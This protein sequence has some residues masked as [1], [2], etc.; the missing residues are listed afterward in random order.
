MSEWWEDLRAGL[1]LIRTRAYFFAGAQGPLS[2]EVRRAVTA[3]LDRWDETGWHIHETAWRHLDDAERGLAALVG[4]SPSRVA[5]AGSTTHGM[6]LAAA[7]VLARW[8]RHGAPPA[9]V[10]MHHQGHSAGTY[11]WLNEVRLGAKLELRWADPAPGQRTAD[12]LADRVDGATIA[13]ILSHVNNWDGERIDVPGLAARVRPHRPALLV[14]AAQSAG[15]LDLRSLVE[16]ADF[17]AMPAYKWLLGPAGVAFLVVGAEWIADPGPPMPGWAGMRTPLPLD[18]RALDPAP[19]AASYRQGIPNFFGIAGAAAGIGLL[20][21][22]GAAEVE[23]RIRALTG[24]LVEGLERR[25]LP[26]TTPH[27]WD[28]RAGVLTVLVGTD[29]TRVATA[30]EGEGVVC[31]VERDAL[32]VDVHAYNNEDDLARLLAALDAHASRGA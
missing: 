25:R 1:P 3:E 11:A 12:A 19:T 18:V 26:L 17:V 10:V 9:N 7:A 6:A 24:T 13:V 5:H 27:T 15:A 21:R 2:A 16:C 31:G 22:A 14:D 28:D 32:R 8:R 30:L 4:C 20:N 29:P 23:D